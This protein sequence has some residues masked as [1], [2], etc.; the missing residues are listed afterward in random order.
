MAD[1]TWRLIFNPEGDVADVVSF[2]A[3]VAE[4]R[5]AGKY[6]LSTIT[7]PD[8]VIIQRSATKGIVAGADVRIDRAAASAAGIDVARSIADDR[9]A[10]SIAANR[11]R[12]QRPGCSD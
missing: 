5:I 11:G 3:A 2:G 7:V 8:T 1:E 6:Q 4:G 12:S 10:T 9:G